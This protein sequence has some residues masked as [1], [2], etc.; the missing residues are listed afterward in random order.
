M[1]DLNAT[2]APEMYM[3]MRDLRDIEARKLEWNRRLRD[4]L[5]IERRAPRTEGGTPPPA[6]LAGNHKA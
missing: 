3:V 2:L 1:L 4:L 5:R 6:S